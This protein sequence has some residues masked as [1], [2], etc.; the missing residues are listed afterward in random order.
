MTILAREFRRAFRKGESKHKRFV[1]KY[2]SNNDSQSRPH[3]KKK[4]SIMNATS[5]DTSYQTTQ[6]T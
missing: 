3:K 1:K 2:G 5:L 6:E 4:V